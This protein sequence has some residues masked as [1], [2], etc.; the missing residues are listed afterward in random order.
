MSSRAI[1]LEQPV[2]TT[3]HPDHLTIG[4]RQLHLVDDPLTRC[5]AGGYPTLGWEG[6]PRM[7]LYVDGP[8]GQ[9]VLVRLEADGVYRISTITDPV[10]L[11]MPP[12]DVIGQLIVWLVAHDGRRGYDAYNDMEAKN[13]RREAE[14]DA[15]FEDEM[16][17]DSF[18]RLRHAFKRDGL[19][20]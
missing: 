10:A 17:N 2:D 1:I 15:K 3:V 20:S 5:I 9:W 11:N 16:T 14:I 6:D 13:A 7:A 19:L 12:V 18:P 4:K 8:N